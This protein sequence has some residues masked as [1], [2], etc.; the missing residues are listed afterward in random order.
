MD[1]QQTTISRVK[2]DD[3]VIDMTLDAD[4]V[5]EKKVS[6]SS[7]GMIQPLTL[8]SQ[9]YRIID[10]FHRVAA[11][12]LLRWEYIEAVVRDVPEEAFWDARIQSARQHASISD[13]RL[14]DWVISC[15]K[16]SEWPEKLNL[17]QWRPGKDDVRQNY[18]FRGRPTGIMT[19]EHKQVAE[20]LW[21]VRTGQVVSGDKES[22]A[23]WFDEKATKWSMTIDQIEKVIYG[24]AAVPQPAPSFERIAVE[25]GLNF[26]ERNALAESF[27]EAKSAIGSGNISPSQFGQFANS[28][29]VRDYAQNAEPGETMRHFFVRRKAELER[30]K[31]TVKVS[32][33]TIDTRIASDIRTLERFVISNFSELRNRGG[34]GAA[35]L[36]NGSA[37]MLDLAEKVFPGSTKG[38]LSD[39]ISM[40]NQ[41][42]EVELKEA[43]LQ[44]T[45]LEQQL[46][47]QRGIA[48]NLQGVLVTHSTD[49]SKAPN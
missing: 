1:T 6:M 47:K 19:P 11:A 41:R 21:L 12:K 46:R 4:N 7:N 2:V 43:R 26:D 24:L 14:T 15:W 33:Q 23:A 32:Q 36:L 20:A 28:A 49:I 39:S 17:T 10:G 3:L 13:E 9:D 37:V 44:I 27:M 30:T 29:S 5:Q 31:S 42:L 16:A 45:Q 38:A 34:A 48:G 22:L 8:W 25:Q 40:V 18:K 35:V